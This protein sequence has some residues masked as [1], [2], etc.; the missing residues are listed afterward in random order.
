M[1]KK[2][3]AL[4]VMALFMILTSCGVPG[5]TEPMD[6]DGIFGGNTVENQGNSAGKADN[7]APPDTYEYIVPKDSPVYNIG[8]EVDF[9]HKENKFSEPEVELT[10]TI[11]SAKVYDTARASGIDESKFIQFQVYEE[12]IPNVC[13]L[14]PAEDCLDARFLL[15]DISIRHSDFY[16]E[17]WGEDDNITFL[18][19]I[20]V[21]DD[22]S[23]SPVSE[24]CYLSNGKGSPHSF[25][26]DFTAGET[27]NMQVGWVI[28]A[29]VIKVD[30][31]DVSRLY[32]ATAVRGNED[33]WTYVSLGLSE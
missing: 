4:V 20:Y 17:R 12:F 30:E 10:Y 24:P 9:I 18:T 13:H 31:I 5:V 26:Y 1:R 15:C 2:K 6:S 16:V 22:G 3:L 25:D 32:L 11:N 8:D 14:K 21:Y 28:D 29:E 19:P 27:T 23:Y 33:F 7:D